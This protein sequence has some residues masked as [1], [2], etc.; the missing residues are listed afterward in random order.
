MRCHQTHAS[1][2]HSSW[3]REMNKQTGQCARD[4]KTGTAA[5]S[6]ST[7]LM[8][9]HLARTGHHHRSLGAAI[10]HKMQP[11]QAGNEEV[12]GGAD[13]RARYPCRRLQTS[14]VLHARP[15]HSG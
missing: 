7:L 3:H 8:A 10:S 2:G 4:A 13:C 14:K 12:H 5:T 6:G 15:R 9:A 1:A 11:F